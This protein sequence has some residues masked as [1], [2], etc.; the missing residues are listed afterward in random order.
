MMDLIQQFVHFGI[1]HGLE[2]VLLARII[3]VERALRLAKAPGNIAHRRLLEPRFLKKG[4]G[5]IDYLLY[6]DLIPLKRF[7]HKGKF[8]RFPPRIWLIAR[9]SCISAG[10]YIHL[11][12]PSP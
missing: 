12:H 3:V 2:N 8:T 9:E 10:Q 7:S 4:S 1:D 6:Y 11:S 5:S